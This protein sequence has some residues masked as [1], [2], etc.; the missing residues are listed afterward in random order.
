MSNRVW[1]VLGMAIV[2]AATAGGALA[3]P[4]EYEG[5]RIVSVTF[6][7]ATQPLEA[8]QL[9]RLL[10]F[11][12][13]DALNLDDVRRAIDSLYNTGRYLEIAIDVAPA[14]NGVAVTIITT[15]HFFVGQVSVEGADDPPSASQ[16]VNAT[17]LGLGTGFSETDVTQASLRLKTLLQ[18]N[19]FYDAEVKPEISYRAAT[20]EADIHFVL[21]L[22]TRAKFSQPEITGE[23][24][25]EV[26]K[27]SGRTNW[28][29][30]WG[31]LGWRQVT[32]NRVQQGLE[33]VRRSYLKSDHLLAKVQMERMDYNPATKTVTPH[34]RIEA[35]PEVRVKTEG[36]KISS[37]HLKQL[38]PVY[39]EQS[40]DQDLLVEGQ[41]KVED[42]FQSA[43]YFDV[44][45]EFRQDQL[46]GGEQ[47]IV[48]TITRGPRYK[49]VKLDVQGNK[50][51]TNETVR[52]RLAV[53]PASLLQYRQGRFSLDLLERDKD[54][55]KDLYNANG[56]RDV[57]VES[58]IVTGYKGKELDLAV[59]ITIEEGPQWFVSDLD[60]T[61]VDLRLVAVIQDLVQSA[62]GQPYSSF[63]V[64]TD[65]D[66]ILNYY[67][68][69]G[70]PEA[71]FDYQATPGPR[72]DTMSLRY[73]V[74][75]GRRNFVRDVIITGLKQ[76]NEKLVDS[77]LAVAPGDPLSQSQMVDGQR[78]LYDLGIFAKVN[79]A[80]QNPEGRERNKY[81]LYQFEE[82]SRYSVSTALGAEIA[83]IGGGDPNSLQSP[84]GAVGFS[85]RVSLGLSRNNFMGIGHTIGVLSRF[86][87]IQK[88]VALNY[89]APQFSGNENNSL[90]FSALWDDSRNVRTFTSR[91]WEGNA[92]F[93]HRLSRATTMQYR[94]TYRRVTVDENTLNIS[95]SLIPLF[96]QPARVGLAAVTLIQD[97]RDDP[98]DSHRGYYNTVDIGVAARAFA[99]QTQ[100][101]RV[102]W[103]NSTY[104]QLGKDRVLARST[105]FGWLYNYGTSPIPLPERFFA[106]GASSHRAFPENQAGPRDLT[107][108]FPIGGNAF[109]VNSIEYRFPLIGQSLGGVLFH[110]AGNVYTDLNSISFRYRQRGKT[111]FDYMVHAVGFG[112]RYRTP[113]GPVRLDLAFSPN[114]PRFV[115]YEGTRED[116][117]LGNGIPNV[118]QRIS[119]FQFHFSLGQ[120]F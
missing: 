91:R 10:P 31:L 89:L 19:G 47:A 59:A 116:L 64:A 110:D 28:Q 81:V 52:E 37:G 49:L 94:L 67:F 16:L 27:I 45:V 30:W 17:K 87:N 38:I 88:R 82:A 3:S 106:G 80:V 75:E 103:R 57:K 117:L 70:Y 79:M 86:S 11:H 54:A 40:V 111:D 33:R 18:S 118:A 24:G 65:R 97:R 93:S 58:K 112:F 73:T 77:R 100:Y 120:S 44:K 2:A 115:G 36:D 53:R 43:G 48:Y 25:S 42:F 68:N 61:G 107:T 22:G 56:F 26:G 113:I 74:Q 15:P 90:S 99:S 63:N 8:D 105:N 104:Y 98:I 39:Q 95:A 85:P 9:T 55:I 69:N 84:A 92:Q 62:A 114:S 71:R 20:E 13:N 12:P 83:R 72:P 46:E 41:R 109:L 101:G 14:D 108:G 21:T 60:V 5:K 23:A 51:F 6:S 102:V 4:A 76:T 119:R 32:E 50:Y 78:R 29:K 96:S 1:T 66:N 34:L 7:P 35:G